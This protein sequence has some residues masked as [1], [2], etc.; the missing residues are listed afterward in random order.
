MNNL[1]CG[2]S[3]M[4]KLFYLKLPEILFQNIWIEIRFKL[5]IADTELLLLVNIDES[6]ANMSQLHMKRFNWGK[7][8]LHNVSTFLSVRKKYVILVYISSVKKNLLGSQPSLT[9]EKLS[10]DK[11]HILPHLG[12]LHLKQSRE[13]N[14]KIPLQCHLKKVD[15][16]ITHLLSQLFPWWCSH[17]AILHEAN[18]FALA[19]FFF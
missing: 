1:V 9:F 5:D 17:W 7:E 13:A 2:A 10:K 18:S 16:V 12:T 14:T 3:S 19:N 8:K 4:L 11:G 6:L 15:S